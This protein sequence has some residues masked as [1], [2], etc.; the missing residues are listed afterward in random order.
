MKNRGKGV[1]KREKA[2]RYAPYPFSFYLA[3]A[4]LVA[5]SRATVFLVVRLP[6]QI[7]LGM[8]RGFDLL[9][10]ICVDWPWVFGYASADASPS[11][12]QSEFCV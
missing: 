4:H 11:I 7:S 1:G 10:E 9:A 6:Y 12:D 5:L 8:S 3:V 2:L